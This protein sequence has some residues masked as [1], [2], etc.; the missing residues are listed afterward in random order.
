MHKIQ[1]N[2]GNNKCSMVDIQEKK[3]DKTQII[4][5]FSSKVK[6]NLSFTILNVMYFIA[7]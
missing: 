7:F 1:N 4:T 3:C 2:Y 5:K 6:Y